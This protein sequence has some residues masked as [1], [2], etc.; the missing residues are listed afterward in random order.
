MPGSYT[1]MQDGRD[2]SIGIYWRQDGQRMNSS[3]LHYGFSPVCI[4]MPCAPAI[5][6]AGIL[7]V[8]G[9][10]KCVQQ[11]SLLTKDERDFIRLTLQIMGSS[12][13][14]KPALVMKCIQETEHRL[15]ICIHLHGEHWEIP[16]PIGIL[17]KGML[18]AFKYAAEDLKIPPMIVSEPVAPS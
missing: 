8:H 17:S 16:P 12:F 9:M 11:Y 14:E 7:E 13:S 6:F 1:I 3:E 18:D 2:H 5:G 10:N 15:G 4:L